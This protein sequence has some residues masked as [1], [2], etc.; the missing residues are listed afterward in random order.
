MG[1]PSYDDLLFAA[2]RR[3]WELRVAA[4][5]ARRVLLA[6]R[7]RADVAVV[8]RRVAR[9][10]SPCVGSSPFWRQVGAVAARDGR[11]AYQARRVRGRV[12]V[13]PGVWV[14][15]AVPVVAA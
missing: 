6:A 8:A 4:E 9:S 12:R 5:A 3:Y 7:L 15:V 1:Q 13:G 2:C 14:W 10:G 11:A